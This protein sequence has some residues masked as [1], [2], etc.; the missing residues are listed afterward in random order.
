MQRHLIYLMPMP[1]TIPGVE[2]S[3]PGNLP[4]STYLPQIGANYLPV[5]NP[6]PYTW[7]GIIIIILVGE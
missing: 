4:S 1:A 7:K 2:A 5:P 3:C 6:S